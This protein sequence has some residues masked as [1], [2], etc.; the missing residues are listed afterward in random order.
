LKKPAS[1]LDSLIIAS[2][3]SQKPGI[4]SVSVAV[5]G[6]QLDGQLE[7]SFRGRPVPL[8]PMVL[9]GKND[10]RF[11]I[12]FVQRDGLPGEL[13]LAFGAASFGAINQ[14]S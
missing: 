12:G 1:F 8:V 3:R 10:M 11:G 7:L 9:D 14:S 13:S 5:V 4:V 6:I 2:H